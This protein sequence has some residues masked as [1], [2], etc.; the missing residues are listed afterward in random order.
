MEKNTFK[1]TKIYINQLETPLG[2]D[3]KTPVFSWQFQSDAPNMRQKK[4]RLLVARERDGQ[5]CWDSGIL[6]TDFSLGLSYAG[7]PLEPECRYRVTLTAWNQRDEAQEAESWFETGLLNPAP[8]AWEGAQ[9]IGA[10]EYAVTSDTIGA[11][12]LETT[13]QIKQGNKAGIVFGANDPRLLDSSKNERFLEGENYFQFLLNIEAS[14]F[15]GHSLSPSYDT[16]CSPADQENTSAAQIEIY[17]VGYDEKDRADTPLYILPAISLTTGKPLITQENKYQPHKLRIEVVGNG[18]YTYLDCEKIDEVRQETPMGIVKGPRCLNPLGAYDVTTFPRLCQIGY[19][20]SEGTE[21]VF[22]GLH[23]RHLRTPSR[24]FYCLPGKQ[25]TGPCRELTDPTCHG[26]PMLRKSFSVTGKIKSARLYATARGIYECSING[27]RVGNEYFAP[28]ASQYDK[29]LM[30]QTYDVTSLLSPG[31]NGIGCILSSGWWSD[32][33]SFRLHNFN[34]WGDRTSFLGK[35]VICYEDGRREVLVTNTEDWDYF[36]E[37]PYQY[38]GFFNGEHYDARKAEL[39]SSFSREDFFAEGMKKPVQIMPEPIEETE[40]IFPGAAVWPAL[41]ETEPMLV[42][43]FQAPVREIQTFTAKSMTEP[44]P[45]VYIYDL[46]QEI[47]GVPVLSFHEKRGQRITIRYGEMLYPSLPQY[48]KLAGLMLQANLREASN[49]DIYI[50]SGEEGEVYQPRFT[51]HGY[52]YIEI[53]GLEHP[54]A[55]TDVRSLLLSSIPRITGTFRCDQELINRFVSNVTYSQYCNFISIP[56]D[57]PQRNERMGWLGD[58]HIFCKTANYQSDAKT[59]YLRN[60]QAMTDMQTADGRLPSIAPFG[61]GFGGLTYES[62]MILIV[63]ELYQFYGDLTVV[64]TFYDAM[65]RWMK[66]ITEL[67]MPGMPPVRFQEWLGDWLAP[68]PADDYLIWNAFH[69]RNAR[70]MQFF[71]EKLGYQED[72]ADFARE[73]ARTKEYWNE[74]FVDP[75]SKRTKN[76]DGTLCDVQGSYSIALDCDIFNEDSREAA[77]AHLARTTQ[78]GNYTIQSGFF[79]TGP[80]NPMLSKGGRSDLAYRT[81]T[82]TDYPSW[83]YPVTQG[84]TTIWERWNSYTAEE[85]FG[86]NNSMN[87]FNHYS[88]GSVLS[89]LYET[90]LGIRRDEAHPGY[91]HFTLQ[92][93]I[94]VFGFAKGGIDTPHGRIESGW[95]RRED[96]IHYTFRI[97]ANTTADVIF[98][99]ERQILGSGTYELVWNADSAGK[100]P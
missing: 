41:N 26:L 87:S 77:F 64:E 3:V 76:A 14:P 2:L 23:V 93:E 13:I 17:R 21:A 51:F 18:A 20:A 75:E 37:G 38:A 29:H 72:A 62:A 40:G 42:G 46:G 9:W 49:T 74:T 54:L 8:D 98:G 39:Y 99:K 6:E 48:G 91:Q 47:A 32:S 79:G 61:G 7:S 88:L 66:A 28:G 4:I 82:Q 52:R 90:V 22:D 83:L 84:A 55:L 34:Y 63:Y 73:A 69:Y 50:C 85:G 11:F 95:E 45:G 96:G 43:N 78:E 81:M 24:E 97:P 10:P 70:K 30:Y 33:F 86:E 65:K 15:E 44:L 100:M 59:F 67:G 68:E 60:L 58:T 89:W 71:A 1:I 31:K 16:S 57:C 53:S 94:G 19:V 12:V 56:T 25:L 36:G 35:L 27:Q 92:P 5:V 80:I